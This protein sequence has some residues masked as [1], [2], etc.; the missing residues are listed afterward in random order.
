MVGFCRVEYT[1]YV[2]YPH[3]FSLS[4]HISP[5]CGCEDLTSVRKFI[6]VLV[7]RTDAHANL[8]KI[9]SMYNPIAN[10]CAILHTDAGL[11]NATGVL[12]ADAMLLLMMLIGLL[13]HPHRNSVGMWKFLYQQVILVLFLRLARNAEFPLAYNLDNVSYDRRNTACG[14]SQFRTPFEDF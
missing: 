12:V 5:A 6:D 8:N 7:V 14:W 11:V 10:A 4:S 9:D 2:S 3:F 13:R 1:E